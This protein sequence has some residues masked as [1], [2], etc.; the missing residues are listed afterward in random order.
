MIPSTEADK[1]LGRRLG[2]ASPPVYDL[3]PAQYSKVKIND[4]TYTHFEKK[5]VI[6]RARKA[7]DELELPAGADER[8]ELDKKEKEAINAK[9]RA[10]NS[11]PTTSTSTEAVKAS[12]ADSV[13]VPPAEPVKVS[14]PMGSGLLPSG[15][16]ISDLPPIQKIKRNPEV[17]SD[18]KASGTKSAKASDNAKPSET[19]GRAI[20]KAKPAPKT[21]FS[22][23]LEKHRAGKRGTSMPNAKREGGVASPRPA[24]KS[25]LSKQTTGSKT[26]SAKAPFEE[27]LKRV[28]HYSDS[29]SDSESED[30]KP[31]PLKKT[32]ALPARAQ[33]PVKATAPASAPATVQK[34][35]QSPEM[36]AL[37]LAL[38]GPEAEA[39]YAAEKAAEAAKEAEAAAEAAV[40]ATA[41]AEAAAANAAQLALALK[42]RPAENNHSSY[43]SFPKKAKI[44]PNHALLGLPAR[45]IEDC[46]IIDTNP[47]RAEPIAR[48][49]NGSHSGNGS[50]ESSAKGSPYAYANG[51]LAMDRS[52]SSNGSRDRSQ[53]MNRSLNNSS[54]STLGNRPSSSAPSPRDHS[55]LR[56]RYEQLSPIYY[57]LAEKLQEVMKVSADPSYT[58][59]IT[60]RMEEVVAMTAE[61][62]K[63]N[64]EMAEISRWFGPASP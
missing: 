48:P 58:P 32:K 36:I 33:P 61:Y 34:Q 7:F 55:K 21:V 60:Y 38:F 6:K 23:E 45:P 10:S 22:K 30:E 41:K 20:K 17:D 51:S 31:T 54:Q 39:E 13:K 37:G 18:A 62:Q 11:P 40:K 1:Q 63:I 8:V 5:I 50:N 24:A 35:K 53:S 59:R 56:E 25:T 29:E 52:L 57:T 26:K 9:A 16:K 27:R 64:A 14:P 19:L 3:Q 46:Q 43:P 2:S 44:S 42:K 47:L 12:S 28:A 4:W 49:R 15:R